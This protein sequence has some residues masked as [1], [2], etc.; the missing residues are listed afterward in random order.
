MQSP[1]NWRSGSGGIYH[2]TSRAIRKWALFEDYRDK[3]RYLEILSETQDKYPFK[4]H[5]FC[6][7]KNH[8]HLL[9]EVTEYQ[10][11]IIMKHLNF[12][13]ARYFNF[14]HS[15]KGHL[16]EGRFYAD[17]IPTISKFLNTSRYIHLNPY[18]ASAVQQAE[19]YRWSS[20][21]YFVKQV[22][23]SILDKAKTLSHFPAPSQENYKFFVEEL[24][25]QDTEAAE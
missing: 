14:R 9:I 16:F 19:S 12:R 25:W 20:Y 18:K 13:Y 8:V 6:L 24:K 3:D 10:P 2:I 23:C 21:Y 11:S 17:P 1:R 5:A 4:L 15:Y 22:D 7:M